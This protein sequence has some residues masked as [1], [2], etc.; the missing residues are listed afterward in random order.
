MRWTHS[1]V[2]EVDVDYT[3]LHMDIGGDVAGYSMTRC[4]AATIIMTL[5][6]DDQKTKRG[7]VQQPSPF[8]GEHAAN[9]T[10]ATTTNA[11]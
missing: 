5:S 9:G 4:G 2:I 11:P 1:C 7:S 8:I 6:A 3:G 10:S